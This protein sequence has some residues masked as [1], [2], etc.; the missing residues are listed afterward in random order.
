[1]SFYLK[2]RNICMELLNIR[3]FQE[4]SKAGFENGMETLR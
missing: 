1:M 4:R 2:N 3:K